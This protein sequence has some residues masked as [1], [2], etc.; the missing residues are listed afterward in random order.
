MASSITPQTV[1]I[2]AWSDLKSIIDS[3]P[4]YKYDHA[5]K[6]DINEIVVLVRQSNEFIYFTKIKYD[7]ADYTDYIDNYA[8]GASRGTDSTINVS[9]T[10]SD[11]FNLDAF[12]RLRVGVPAS[13]FDSKQV[14]NDQPLFWVSHTVGSSTITY[15]PLE[16]SSR[17]ACT[18]TSGD[19]AVRQTRE[20]FNYQPGKSLK[21]AMT[22]VMGAA[23]PNVRQR[24]GLFD[25]DN[26]IFFEQTSAGLSLVLRTDTS[27]TPIDTSVSQSNWN[28]DTLDGSGKSQ[29]TID[30]SKAQIYTFD[31]QWLGV[32]R[33]RVGVSIAGGVY[34][35]H[36]F[37]H[38]NQ[39][40]KVYIRTPNLPIRYEIENIDTA[41]STTSMDAICVEVESE[42]GYNP[43]GVTRTAS[44]GLV[45]TPVGSSYIP[46]LSVRLKDAYNRASILP[47]SFKMYNKSNTLVH[48][49][50]I[51]N[52]TLTGPSWVS[53]SDTSIAEQDVTA[54]ALTGG[55]FIDDMFVSSQG[56]D[57]NQFSSTVPETLL[58]ILANYAGDSDTFTLIAKSD[59]S[60]SNV[61]GSILFREIY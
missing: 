49:K 17:L 3:N 52:G 43:K 23:K 41:A 34:Y 18:T 60:T 51:Y 15:I 21:V 27:G 54:T 58:K 7:T 19:R 13:L 61:V 37:L 42:G 31:I 4:N 28:I 50:L 35:V 8:S 22:G 33:A 47:I 16:S 39:V 11:S 36:E 14:F 20:Y 10:F 29:L 59:G 5:T 2:P 12:A 48:C 32:G 38:A 25:D 24:L 57:R 6:D 56:S 26:G 1:E 44:M 46:V 45:H 30:P 9:T 53:V 40:D 55:E